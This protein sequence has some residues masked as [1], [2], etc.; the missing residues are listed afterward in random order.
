M[1]YTACVLVSCCKKNNGK[2]FFNYING[3]KIFTKYIS[4][5]RLARLVVIDE[6]KL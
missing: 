5:K 6:I 3:D 4:K 2:V 1:R